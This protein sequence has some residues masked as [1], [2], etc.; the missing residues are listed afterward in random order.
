MAGENLDENV[1]NLSDLFIDG[2]FSQRVRSGERPEYDY[3]I[4]HLPKKDGATMQVVTSFVAGR[5]NK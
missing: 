1:R 2:Y 3:P 4:N 5:K